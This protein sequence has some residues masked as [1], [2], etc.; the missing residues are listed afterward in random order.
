MPERERDRRGNDG[1][2]EAIPR[3]Q[4]AEQGAAERNFLRDHHAER[5]EKENVLSE[6]IGGSKL[7]RLVD[8]R[9]ADDCRR[10]RAQYR[11]GQSGDHPSG[12]CPDRGS[13]EGAGSPQ[14][15]RRGVESEKPRGRQRQDEEGRARHN[16]LPA[17]TG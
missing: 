2:A 11:D 3:E 7:E 4:S 10:D 8:E 14:T 12:G 1:V 5:E 16:E 15:D 17:P 6:V 9:L 13:A